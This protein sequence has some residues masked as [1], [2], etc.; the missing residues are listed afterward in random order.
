MGRGCG[1]R[2]KQGLKGAN[3]REVPRQEKGSKARQGRAQGQS[4][5]VGQAKEE[6]QKRAASL[7]KEVCA[8]AGLRERSSRKERRD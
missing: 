2:R 5:G 4:R 3:R 7:A 8:G 6:A 1:G